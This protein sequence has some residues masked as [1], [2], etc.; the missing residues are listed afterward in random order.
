MCPIRS[1]VRSII[2]SGESWTPVDV[3]AVAEALQPSFPEKKL[4]E[5]VEIVAEV[6]VRKSGRPLVWE[7]WRS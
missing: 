5:L 2:G 6:A 7:R 1:T 3:Y 4:N